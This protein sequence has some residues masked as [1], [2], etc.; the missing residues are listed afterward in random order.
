ML[1]QNINMC[2]V[3]V[4]NPPVAPPTGV[5]TIEGVT[6]DATIKSTD[7]YPNPPSWGVSWHLV[8]SIIC[9]TH[10]PCRMANLLP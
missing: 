2:P 5:E 1:N 8:G 4:G 6:F 7:R 10:H 3:L 9:N